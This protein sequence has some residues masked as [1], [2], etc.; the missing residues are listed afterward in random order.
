MDGFRF[1]GGSS[2]FLTHGEAALQFLHQEYVKAPTPG[3]PDRGPAPQAT[4]TT[5]PA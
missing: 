3:G 4:P 5:T 2:Y 1:T